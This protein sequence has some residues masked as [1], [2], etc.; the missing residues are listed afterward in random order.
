MMRK[1]NVSLVPEKSDRNIQPI[2]L[3]V[4]RHFFDGMYL[5]RAA[6]TSIQ[7]ESLNKGKQILFA[8]SMRRR[9]EGHP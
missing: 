6:V 5:I 3:V 2:A 7:A 8:Q 9:A 1:G 4:D